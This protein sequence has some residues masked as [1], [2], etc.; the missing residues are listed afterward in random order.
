MCGRV[1]EQYGGGRYTVV[2][3]WS[4]SA[5]ARDC[6]MVC[7]VVD[8]GPETDGIVPDVLEYKLYSAV[9]PTMH[10]LA[11]ATHTLFVT[12]AAGRAGAT[13]RESNHA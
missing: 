5:G 1:S 11:G 6:V 2:G 9:G 7:V 4:W 12:N 13:P 10:F 3:E 8:A